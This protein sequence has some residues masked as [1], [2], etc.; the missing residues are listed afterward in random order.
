MTNKLTIVKKTYKKETNH[1][2]TG[3]SSPVRTAHMSVCN[4]GIQYSTAQNNTDN[5]PSY[6]P[7]NRHILDSL[8][9]KASTTTN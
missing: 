2:P 9:D 6:S 3:S 5:L 4:C 7:D 8:S 1:K